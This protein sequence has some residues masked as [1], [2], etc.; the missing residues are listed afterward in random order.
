MNTLLNPIPP[1][2]P[3]KVTEA[4]VLAAR[5]L[6]LP[7]LS[8]RQALHDWRQAVRLVWAASDP[9][10]V[11]A[12]A[13]TKAGDFLS[14]HT[15]LGAFL[16]SQQPGCTAPLSGRIGKYI[17]NADGTVSAVVPAP[18]P[19]VAKAASAPSGR[20]ENAGFEKLRVS[21]PQR[22]TTSAPAA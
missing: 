14:Y 8:F 6:R 15:A 1:P 18:R 13:G 4:Q 20:G 5:A 22:E 16:E 11:L 2:P 12:I 21:A 17:V 3:A 9:A 10:A 7:A 19:A